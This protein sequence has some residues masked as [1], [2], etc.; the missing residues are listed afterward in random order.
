MSQS[1]Q[2]F[3]EGEVWQRRA[4]LKA[5]LLSVLCKLLH[6]IDYRYIFWSHQRNC[7]SPVSITALFFP[8]ARVPAC[9]RESTCKEN[10]PGVPT[11]Q[12][13]RRVAT[14]AQVGVSPNTAYILRL[15]C[16]VSIFIKGCNYINSIQLTPQSKYPGI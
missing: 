5:W 6:G 1:S 11:S 3:A 15:A 2:R 9:R 16:V 7:G 10:Y 8:C 13:Y 12:D 14:L 4:R